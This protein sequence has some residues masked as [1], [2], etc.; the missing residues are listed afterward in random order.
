MT[1]DEIISRLKS[2]EDQLRLQ[3]PD[4]AH[5]N[6]KAILARSAKVSEEWGELIE[7]ILLKLGLQRK[8]K[9]LGHDPKNL[10]KEFGDVFNSL[11]LLGIALHIDVKTAIEM[12]VGEMYS[13]Y[14]LTDEK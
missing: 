11:I 2:I 6:E 5:D 3:Y 10:E 14:G 7:E 1:F 4:L 13:K 8:E 9:L 12:R